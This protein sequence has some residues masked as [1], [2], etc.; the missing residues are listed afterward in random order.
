MR[1]SPV[2]GGIL[3]LNRTAATPASHTRSR[4]PARFGIEPLEGR[5]FLAVDFVIHISVDGL[6]PDGVTTQGAANLPNFYRL[7]TQGAFTDNARTD[8]DNTVTLTNHTGM[9]TGRPFN[10]TGGHGYASDVDVPSNITL[11]TN[12]GAYIASVWDVAHD[13]GRRTGL[14]ASKT[15]FSLYNNTYD[16]DTTALQGGAPDVTGVDNGRD[17]IDASMINADESLMTNSFVS[18]MGASPINYSLVHYAGPDHE[19]HAF[20]WMTGAYL[21]AVKKVDSELGKIFNLIDT[22]PALA[23]RTAIILTADH[24]GTG[25]GHSDATNALD[26][27]IPF[28]VWGPGVTAGGDL[29]GMNTATRQDPAGSRPNHAAVPQP[30]RNTD[31]A[32]LALDL[33]DLPS[34]PGSTFNFNQNLVVNGTAVSTRPADPTNLVAV[35]VSGTQVNITWTDNATNEVGYKIERSTDGRTFY[36]Q[37]G[38]GVNGKGYVNTGLTPGKRY[39][40]RVYAYNGSGNSGFSNVASAVTGTTSNPM[41]APS[42][43][44]AVAVSS[45]QI[46]L[47][48]ADNA[49]AETGYRIERSTNGTTFTFLANV[50]A[51]ANSFNNTGLAANTKYYYRVQALGSPNS[52]FSNTA[53]ATTQPTGTTTPAA[54]SALAASAASSSQINLSWADN[55][56]N[57]T[58]FRIERSTNGTTFAFLAN[59]GANVKNYSNTGLPA[60][61][62]YYYRVQAIGSPTSSAFSNVANATTQTTSTGGPLAAPTNLV[63]SPSTSVANSL[64]L[65]WTDNATAESAYKIERST[66]GVNFSPLAGGSANMNFYR[67]TGLTPGK[68]YFYRVYAVNSAGAKSGFSNVASAVVPITAAAAIAPTVSAFAT[69]PIKLEDAVWA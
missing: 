13:N 56:G 66:D 23:G 12:K 68:R 41:A 64:N 11:H 42:N 22:T 30:I 55:S 43:L 67:N 10:G 45:S 1:F 44:G 15:K 53:N 69:Q 61:T 4:Y 35:S 59:V 58:G 20:G 54:P 46:N 29:Y 47:S 33:L 18:S 21:A 31:V 40:Y 62:K 52:A 25:T 17:K 37:A 2:F 3:L 6:R 14:F 50:G 27:T 38:T 57:E 9:V 60:N 19:G 24:G 34:V 51:N 39:Y 49:T 28:Y 7:R 65:S 48:W 5:Q 26:Y 36:P 8:F 16:A 32:N 63:V